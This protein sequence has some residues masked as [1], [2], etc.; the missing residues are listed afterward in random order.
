MVNGIFMSRHL[1][2]MV[3]LGKFIT[4]PPDLAVETRH[5]F[6]PTI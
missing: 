2:R 3:L 4:R 5:P 1:V 6:H